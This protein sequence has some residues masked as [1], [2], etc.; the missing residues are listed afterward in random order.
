[1][2]FLFP[3]LSVSAYRLPLTS[4]VL[5]VHM[6]CHANTRLGLMT[7]TFGRSGATFTTLGCCQGARGAALIGD[8]GC[9]VTAR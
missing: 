3:F 8:L 7:L 2:S 1:M 6:Q 4:F 5:P 9:H